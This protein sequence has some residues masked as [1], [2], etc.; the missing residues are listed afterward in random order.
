M[1]R[2]PPRSKRT[3][4][5]FPYTTLF[6]SRVC[7]SAPLI[8][9]A[10]KWDNALT[11]LWRPPAESD[12]IARLGGSVRLG[13]IFGVAEYVEHVTAVIRRNLGNLWFYGSL[14]ICVAL[15]VAS[16]LRPEPV[17]ME[18]GA[19]YLQIGRA[20]CRERGCQYV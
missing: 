6:R 9:G 5:L 2:R 18:G 3:D 19:R 16:C 7:P 15:L 17:E 10:S 13:G 8:H 14:G 4:T 11:T 1:R 20:S 12:S